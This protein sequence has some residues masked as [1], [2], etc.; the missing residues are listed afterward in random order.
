MQ[1]QDPIKSAYNII[2]FVIGN[3][4]HLRVFTFPFDHH[5]SDFDKIHT[6]SFQVSVFVVA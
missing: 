4:A 1:D 5:P 6:L 2:S 3:V